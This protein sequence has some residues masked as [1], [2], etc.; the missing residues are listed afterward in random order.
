M[1]VYTKQQRIAN[2]AKYRREEALSSLNHHMDVDWL[3]EAFRRVR[4]DAAPGIDGVTYEQ[5]AQELARHLPDLLNRVKSGRYRAP[6]VKRVYIPKGNGNETRPIGIPTLEDKIVQRAVVMLLEPIYE[7]DF[8][9]VSYGYRPKRSAHQALSRIWEECMNHRIGWILDADLRKFFDTLDHS[10]VRDI[11][12]LR[13][14]DGVICR[15][16]SKWLKAGILEEGILFYPES[17]TP[18]GGVI[19]PMLSNIYLHEVLDKWFVEQIVP[20]L[21]GYG[22]LVRFADD[23]IMGFELESDARRVLAVLPKR[24]ERFSLR[25]HPDKTRLVR[26]KRP[27]GRGPQPQTFDFLSL[28][29][30]W[31]RTR[32]GGWA[33]KRKTASSRFSRALR[34]IYQWCRG[35]RHDPI[36]EQHAKLKVKMKGHYNYFGVTG[37]FQC[38]KNFKWE[39]ERIWFKWLQRRD[40]SRKLTWKRFS[41]LLKEHI[42]LPEPRIMHGYRAAKP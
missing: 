13:V 35:H 16:V 1:N 19:S 36:R 8:C 22:F 6:A 9:D 17:G 34:S 11:L 42:P 40:R 41:I 26:F 25:I 38:L 33:V 27:D 37:N 20:K 3:K 30:Y 23:F 18:Q 5:Y 7:N 2:T 15:L 14:R 32:R 21:D 39:V 31:G 28:T 10:H 12:R 24:C 4:R 29:H